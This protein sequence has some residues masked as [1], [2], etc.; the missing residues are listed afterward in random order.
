MKKKRII[1]TILIII[2]ALGLI[3]SAMAITDYNRAKNLKPPL[4]VTSIALDQHGAGIYHGVGYD[5]WAV[6]KAFNGN[7]HIL[8]D[9]R[10]MLFGRGN[11]GKKAI[12]NNYHLNYGLMGENKKS[13]FEYIEAL[14]F[15]T[16]DVSGKQETYTEYVNGNDV[17][18]MN[19][20]FYNDVMTG[21]EYE[22]HNLEAAYEYA[23]K[24][25]KDLEMTYGEK[26]TYP[27]TTP[28]DKDCFDTLKSFSELK[29][30]YTYYEDWE[31]VFEGEKQENINKM[32]EGKD[33]SRIDIHFELS[34]IDENKATVSTKY[35]ALP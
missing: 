5:V 17:K 10:F 30:H 35:V 2:L 23:V 25:R 14:E 26:S 11:G 19:L 16:P 28:K 21:F 13:V 32:L 27:T 3:W 33:Y 6:S 1:S 34:V 29:N 12:S 31:A 18:A 4:F 7:E 15:V 22:Y 20:I 8:Y 9:M 24:L